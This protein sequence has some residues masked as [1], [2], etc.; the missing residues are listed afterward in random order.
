MS[1]P[2]LTTTATRKATSILRE[3]GMGPFDNKNRKSLV[4]GLG[5][6]RP[7]VYLIGVICDDCS[8]NKTIRRRMDNGIQSG[9]RNCWPSEMKRKRVGVGQG[10]SWKWSERWG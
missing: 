7:A 4:I 1:A 3:A 2:T 8:N 9:R 5:S 10:P 6:R